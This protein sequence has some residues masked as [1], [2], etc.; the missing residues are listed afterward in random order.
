MFYAKKNPITDISISNE[1]LV[2]FSYTP[3]YYLR[4][5]LSD[6]LADFPYLSAI[7]ACAAVPNQRK[8]LFGLLY[9]CWFVRLLAVSDYRRA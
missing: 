2:I 4:N 8:V 7:A 6:R 5:T 3:I 1:V 9:N